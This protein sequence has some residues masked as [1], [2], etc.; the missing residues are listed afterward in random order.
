MN[1]GSFQIIQKGFVQILFVQ[2]FDKIILMASFGTG[3]S[4]EIALF[5][6]PLN[7]LRDIITF[8]TSIQ[9]VH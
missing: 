4:D 9:A 5:S 7:L 8:G 6:F 3:Q 2:T 1:G